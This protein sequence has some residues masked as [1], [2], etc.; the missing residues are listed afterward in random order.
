MARNRAL[1]AFTGLALML[2]GFLGGYFLNYPRTVH[3][4]VDMWLSPWDNHVRGGEQVVHAL[5]AMSS[6]GAFGAGSGS[7]T[8]RSCPPRTPT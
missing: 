2:A 7:A 1:L 6:G 8:P 5:W 3:Q 4:R